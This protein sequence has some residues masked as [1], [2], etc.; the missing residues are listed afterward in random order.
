MY[1]PYFTQLVIDDICSW[2]EKWG[3]KGY[4]RMARSLPSHC[5]IADYAYYPLVEKDV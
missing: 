2:G 5:G 4:V 3:E 1:F